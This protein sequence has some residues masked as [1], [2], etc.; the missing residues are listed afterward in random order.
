MIMIR[1]MNDAPNRFACDTEIKYKKLK[2]EKEGNER[3]N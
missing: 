3:M 2:F 1:D